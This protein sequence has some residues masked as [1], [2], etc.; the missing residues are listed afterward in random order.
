[1][2]LATLDDIFWAGVLCHPPMN[3]TL[4]TSEQSTAWNMQLFIYF[5]GEKKQARIKLLDDSI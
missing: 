1:M 2:L 5:V 3:L 4:G